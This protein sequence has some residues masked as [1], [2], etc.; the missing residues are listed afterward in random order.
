VYAGVRTFGISGRRRGMRDLRA[1]EEKRDDE[2]M[3]K[4]SE[5]EKRRGEMSERENIGMGKR[6][7]VKEMHGRREEATNGERR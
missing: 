6:G 1:K 7:S 2:R 5:K 3:R 4:A